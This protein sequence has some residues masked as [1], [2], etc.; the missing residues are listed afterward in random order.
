MSAG[1]TR[2]LPGDL[3]CLIP[4]LPDTGVNREAKPFVLLGDILCVKYFLV[5][6]TDLATAKH[7][8]ILPD[9][10]LLGKKKDSIQKKI[11]VCFIF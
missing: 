3:Y 2:G 4:H 5:K 9:F 1:G 11:K 6:P 8:P 10:F 7:F